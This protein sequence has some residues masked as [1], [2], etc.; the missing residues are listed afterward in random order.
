MT[1]FTALALAAIV[2][3][4]AVQTDPSMCEALA[5]V[6]NDWTEGNQAAADDAMGELLDDTD[7]TD[8]AGALKA[9]RLMGKARIQNGD[10][11]PA[12]A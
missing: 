1:D 11:L 6:R 5:D 10:D 12:I 3:L 7:L 2:S 9:H 4:I 8:P